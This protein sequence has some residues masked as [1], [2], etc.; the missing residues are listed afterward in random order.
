MKRLVLVTLAVLAV[1]AATA[2]AADVRATAGAAR[3]PLA[4]LEQTHVV[5]S[6]G[7]RFVRFRQQAG[8]VPVLGAQAVVT[9]APGRDD[10]LVDHT[11]SRIHAPGN[12]DLG[13][14]D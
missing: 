5:R 9:D 2:D 14:D 7:A 10:L 4:Q 12:P 1:P 8:G 13:R 3:A 6:L 11:R